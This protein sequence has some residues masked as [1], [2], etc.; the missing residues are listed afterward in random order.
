MNDF[1]DLLVEKY[2]PSGANEQKRSDILDFVLGKIYAD[3]ND[4]YMNR[5]L[6]IKNRVN[7]LN[8]NLP[9]AKAGEEYSQLIKI[10]DAD[11]LEYWIEGLEETGLYIESEIVLTTND[12]SEIIAKQEVVAEPIVE[13][14]VETI[15]SAEPVDSI[16]SEEEQTSITEVKETVIGFTNRGLVIKGTPS[17]AGDFDI[18]I[19]YKYKGWYEGCNIL[20]RNLKFV[21]NPDPRSL[22]K[23]IPTDKNIKFYKEDYVSE[24]VTVTENEKGPQKDIVAASKRGRSHAHEGKARD[25]HFK[26]S[27]NAD[28]GWYVIAV[29]DGAG[30]AKYSR[31]GSEV[32][33][34]TCVEHCVKALETPDELETAIVELSKAEEGA[35]NR[36]ISTLI[37][38]IIGGAALK[39]H[40]AITDMAAA[41]EDQTRDYSTTLLIAICKKFDFGWF[42]ASFW[43]GDGAMCIYDKE[44]QYLRVLGTPDGGEYAGQTR[45]LTMK[46]IFTPE[47]LMSRLKY[48]IEKDFTALMLMTDGI[49]DPFFE[50]DA[51]VNRIEK[52]ND[53]WNSINEEVELT[54]DN[55]ES[56]YQLLKWLDFWSPGNHD[57]RTIA[58]LY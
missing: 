29:A 24:Y 23:D 12:E 58:I 10:E 53:L 36:T 11:V 26:L 13:E 50:T 19:K 57:D 48:S 22:W 28:N 51:N 38:N 43:V 14:L 37:Y 9:N 33:C 18:T 40:R 45:F 41:N 5:E 31:K 2:F 1:L 52:W 30:S 55:S 34:N 20:E 7:A 39:A 3:Y 17:L 4:Y 56:Q 54:D 25:D 46:E 8:I 42:V 49:S 47:S 44:R 16:S 21:V 32:A 15:E 6:V 27:H 35:S